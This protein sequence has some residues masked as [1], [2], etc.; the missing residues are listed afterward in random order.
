MSSL[1]VGLI[2][3][4]GI[5]RAHAR[6]WSALGCELFVF[7]LEGGDVL[8]EQHGARIVGSEQ[9][10]Y[11]LVDVVDIVTPSSTHKDLA[12]AAI[13]AGKHVVCEKP[14]G[15]TVSDAVEIVAAARTAGV[16]V[17]PA[18]VVRFFPEYA[19][20]KQEVSVGAV[21]ELAVL[22]FSRA[23]QSPAEGSWFFSERHGGG[24]IFDQMI[25]DLDQARWI[26]GE[27]SQ[28]YAVQNPPTMDGVVPHVV[29]AHAVLTHTSGAISH[30]Q[31]VWGPAGLTF[32]TSLDVAGTGG[33]LSFDSALDSSIMFDLPA[34]SEGQSYLPKQRF[35]DSPY[36]LEIRE[37]AAA[38]EGGE[39]PRVSLVDGVMAVAIAEA[40]A[41]SIRSGVAVDLD[42]AALLSSLNEGKTVA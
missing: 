36:A 17:Y 38:F 12:L 42:S 40:A 37:F 2:G 25:H 22:R 27:V 23:G 16:Q 8:A 24:I 31:G 21:G 7:S 30:V 32:R 26:A 11:E 10:L 35:L 14:L 19:R 3:A 28:V 41:E 20:A 4:G 5:S 39:S 1:R 18:H 33:F 29:T 13:A 34:I 6:A 9:E 15:L